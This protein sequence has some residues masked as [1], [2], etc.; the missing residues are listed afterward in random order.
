MILQMAVKTSW[1]NNDS[2]SMEM[3]P[4]KNSPVEGDLRSYMIETGVPTIG[5]PVVAELLLKV[6]EPYRKE[7]CI[8]DEER[9]REYEKVVKRGATDR[10]AFAAAI[11]GELSEAH[12]W[13]QLPRALLHFLEKSSPSVA[14]PRNVGFQPTSHADN[15]TALDRIPSFEMSAQTSKKVYT[16][17]ILRYIIIHLSL[18]LAK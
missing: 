7:G 16:V 2:Y 8:I 10:F 18:I 11:F 1:F 14:N 9:A 15:G 17:M 12:F 5:D 13:L 4:S 6:L 3:S